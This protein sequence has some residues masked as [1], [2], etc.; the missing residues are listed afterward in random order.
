MANQDN[1]K[2]R[3]SLG[4]L[5]HIS[6]SADLERMLDDFRKCKTAVL[7]VPYFD[8]DFPKQLWN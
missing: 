8:T 5:G 2:K 7:G 6:R 4:A 3:R 1:G